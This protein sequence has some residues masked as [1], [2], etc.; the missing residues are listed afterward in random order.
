MPL[1]HRTASLVRTADRR[2]LAT[3]PWRRQ[4]F[5]AAGWLALALAVLG[6]ALPLLPTT[7]FVLLA[8]ACFMRGSQRLHAALLANRW[9]GPML[10][11]WEVHR[12]VPR[13]TKFMAIAM[14]VVS[15]SISGYFFVPILAGQ[16]G[17]AAIGAGVVIYLLR[18]PS[19]PDSDPSPR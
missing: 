2:A 7:P 3:T 14:I 4:L 8:S 1:D 11:Q 13:R 6:V 18:L 5:L 19:T 9:F 16:L 12:V 15:M 10:T 17:L